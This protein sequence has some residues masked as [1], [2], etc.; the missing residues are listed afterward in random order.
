MNILYDHQTFSL[1]NYGGI[2]RYHTELITGIN[3][4]AEHRAQVPLLLTNNTHL[5]ESG[6]NVRSLLPAY[7]IRGRGKFIYYLN[8]A[9]S[10][11]KLRQEPYDV[12]HATYY[13]PYFLPFLKKPF[14]I[15]FHDMIYE[16][17]NGQFK[18]LYKDTNIINDKKMLAERATRI[19]A[20]SE[21]TKKD[22][23]DLLGIEPDK[24][25]VIHH[26]NSLP[27]LVE[28]Y[29]ENTLPYLL[30]VGNRNMYKNF[31]GLLTAIYPLLKRYRVQLL[32]AGG[33]RFSKAEQENIA[34]LGVTGLV[35]QKPIDDQSLPQLYRHAVAF[36]FPS[37]YE[38]F[39]IPI[40]ES[41]ACGCPCIVSNTSS[42]PEV[43]GEAALYIDPASS[44]SMHNAVELLLNDSELRKLL[45]KKGLERL[46]QFSWERAVTET[47]N[48]YKGIN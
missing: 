12:F 23:I 24:I 22:I 34:M 18:E 3:K 39:G 5:P 26:G 28:D 20:V 40:L 16:K 13:N 31:Q 27:I 11:L 48:L 46:T 44:D 10:V 4:T 8:Q 38:G 43:A 25:H 30:Y 17:L 41:F 42:L 47:I 7:T 2:S 9:Y 33:G 29:D 14:V 19:I 1:Q 6:M 15:T 32:C 21:H 45:V 35:E 36:V 37:L